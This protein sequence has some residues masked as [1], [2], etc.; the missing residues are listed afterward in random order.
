[1]A[2]ERP[3]SFEELLAIPGITRVEQ[4]HGKYLRMYFDNLAGVTEKIIGI[5]IR[6]GWQLSEITLE[7]SSLDEIFGQYLTGL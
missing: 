6:Q 4:V 3:P 5:S 1:M 2:L 7:R